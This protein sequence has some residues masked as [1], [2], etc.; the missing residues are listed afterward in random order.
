MIRVS[1]RLVQ[2]PRFNFRFQIVTGCFIPILDLF[3]ALITRTVRPDVQAPLNKESGSLYQGFNVMGLASL[4][5]RLVP[6]KDPGPLDVSKYARLQSAFRAIAREIVGSG[7]LSAVE[8]DFGVDHAFIPQ[9][10]QVCSI[11]SI[12][13]L[14]YRPRPRNSLI[15][16]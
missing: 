15:D 4:L 1:D 5:K 11:H 16:S 13:P 10:L 14:G 2:F 3:P 12:R 9:P 6:K 7:P 8:K